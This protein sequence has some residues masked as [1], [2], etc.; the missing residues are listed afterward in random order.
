MSSL[1]LNRK[2]L[3]VFMEN[4][5]ANKYPDLVDSFTIAKKLMLSEIEVRHTMCSMKELGFIE[6]DEDTHRALITQAGILWYQQTSPLL[7][8]EQG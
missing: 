5:Q 2:I 7:P 3:S 4:I 6:S 1:L 8:K